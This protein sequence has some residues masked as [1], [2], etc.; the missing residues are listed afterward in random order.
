[1]TL[2]QARAIIRKHAADQGARYRILGSDEVHYYGRMPNSA[3]TGWYFINWSAVDLAK[4][5]KA[6]DDGIM[7]QTPQTDRA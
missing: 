3:K 2:T 6:E 1:M 7:A 5:I 4:Q